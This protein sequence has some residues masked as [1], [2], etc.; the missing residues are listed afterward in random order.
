MKTGTKDAIRNEFRALLEEHDCSGTSCTTSVN[1]MNSNSPPPN[2]FVDLND[3]SQSPDKWQNQS[4]VMNGGDA[5][6]TSGELKCPL[7][8]LR[9][10]CSPIKLNPLKPLFVTDLTS[11]VYH[12][13]TKFF[14]KLVSKLF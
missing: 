10:S 12:E 14:L 7:C 8:N 13:K 2:G 11:Q 6:G 5:V 4:S 9:V 3:S 1:S